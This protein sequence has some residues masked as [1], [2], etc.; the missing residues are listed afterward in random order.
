M[1]KK[2]QK[3]KNP[4]NSEGKARKPKEQKAASN[5]GHAHSPPAPFDPLRRYLWEINQYKLLTPEEE[6]SLAVRYYENQDMEA[7]Y[8][9]TTANLRLVVKIA[10]DFQRYWMQN[11][12][13]L[14]QEGNIGLIQAVK[15]FDPYREIKFSYYASYWI[16]AYIL[17]FIMDNWKLVKIG[18]TQVQRK[19]FFN[20]NKEKDRLAYLGFEP[21]PKLLAETLDVRPDQIIEMD[22]RL[23]SWDVSLESPV[24]ADSDDEHKDF[25]PAEQ[26]AVD[27]EL[28]ELETMQIF[29]DR[30]QEFRSTLKDKELVIMDERL[31]AE[32][33]STL[34]AIGEKYDIS[35]ERVRQIQSRLIKKIRAYLDEH[36]PELGQ[37]YGGQGEGK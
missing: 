30:L 6:K 14:I 32:E 13:D 36:A 7:A 24:K 28:S 5:S 3:K 33:P 9:L 10:L 19:L 18:T 20:L 34:Q 26:T 23:S 16:K 4:K 1:E 17:R 29:R 12:L 27:E 21:T 37:E 2:A 25:L 11:L 15:K 35:R 22:Q 31:L 8:R